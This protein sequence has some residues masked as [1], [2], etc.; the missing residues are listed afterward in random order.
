MSMLRFYSKMIKPIIVTTP[1]QLN[2][3]LTYF[4][5][6]SGKITDWTK[7]SWDRMRIVGPPLPN[8]T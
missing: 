1:T 8:L 3:T 2:L 6:D 7:D 4:G 5:T